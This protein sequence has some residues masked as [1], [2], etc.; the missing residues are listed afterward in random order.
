MK[1][2]F[3]IGVITTLLLMPTTWAQTRQ[4]DGDQIQIG[5][6]SSQG[7]KPA[8]ELSD[9]LSV[10][11]QL[12]FPRQTVETVGQAIDYTLLRTGYRIVGQE[13]LGELALRFL[14]LPLPESQRNIGPYQVNDILQILLGSAW[15]LQSDSVTRQVWFERKGGEKNAVSAKNSPVEAKAQTVNPTKPIEALPV[16]KLETKTTG[17]EWLVIPS[18]KSLRD[19]ITRW[20]KQDGKNIVWNAASN[21]SLIGRRVGVDF[22]SVG[23]L[24]EALAK[25]AMKYGQMEQPFAVTLRNGDIYEITD[26]HIS[27]ISTSQ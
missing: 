10:I 17:T 19:I 23:T 22:S 15:V 11:A 8:I 18:D 26:I 7:A 21:Y 25:L 4:A 24:P 12:N 1:Q 16:V 2:G 14:T 9:P 20:G 3:F 13:N 27:P 5:R 6:Y